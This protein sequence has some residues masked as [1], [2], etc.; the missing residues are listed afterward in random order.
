MSAAVRQR[1]REDPVVRRQQ[2]VD[3]A[4][5]VIGQ[6]G[7]NGFTVQLLAEKC[8]LS[9]AGLLYYFGSKGALLVALLDAVE[10]REREVMEPL[11]AF[12]R[13][14]PAGTED[15][16]KIR[17]GLLRK[18]IERFVEHPELGRFSVT[19]QTE[20]LDPAHP[21]HDWF[22][23]RQVLAIGMFESTITGFVA[24]PAITARLLYALMNGLFQQWLRADRMFDLVAA[25]DEGAGAI[26]RTPVSGSR[27]K[28][29]AEL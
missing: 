26:V 22:L 5:R 14:V 16:L 19:L 12:A 24:Q 4:I 11:V 1:V 8:G 20:S 25:W 9:N 6:H 7:F 21:A 17:L 28:L 18:I 3:E 15:S 23:E 2:I 29:V 27:E 13:S 10:R